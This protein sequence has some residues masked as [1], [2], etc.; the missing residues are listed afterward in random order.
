MRIFLAVAIAGALALAGRVLNLRARSAP[1]P[2]PPFRA[3][4]RRVP[5]A[6][7]AAVA[8]TLGDG[9][10][11]LLVH[12]VYAGASAYE[13]RH[14]AAELAT[15][16]LVAAVDLPG[17]GASERPPLRY[18]SE[19]YVRFL[20]G[21]CERMFAQPPVVVA[22]GLSAAF[23]VAAASAEPRFASRLVLCCPT[24]MEPLGAGP[25]L[26]R[27][28]IQTALM[29]PGMGD[30]AVLLLGRRRTV[31]RFVRNYTYFDDSRLEPDAIRYLRAQ[32]LRPGSRF[33]LAAFL[34]G[35]LDCQIRAEMAGLEIPVDIVWGRQAE[36]TPLEQAADFLEAL[37]STRLHVIERCGNSPHLERPHEF[38]AAAFGTDR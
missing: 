6:G 11:V 25:S 27:A 32:I 21:F 37:P 16:H 29:L 15:D 14:V 35:A 13:W 28:A 36:F 1:D 30:M 3:S 8:W 34:A 22:S 20:S 17:F 4:C 12:G 10:P 38:L 24:G 2:G 23:A 19:A 5:R 18:D 7:G 31:D 33:S 26:R 9:P